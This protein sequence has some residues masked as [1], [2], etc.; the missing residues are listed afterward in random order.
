MLLTDPLGLVHVFESP[1][2]ILEVP[3]AKIP[4][5]GVCGLYR[6]RPSANGVCFETGDKCWK[7]ILWLKIQPLLYV[8]NDRRTSMSSIL[9]HE[10]RHHKDWM[11]VIAQGVAEGEKIEAKKFSSY[12]ACRSAVDNW[13]AGME[14]KFARKAFWF[15][16]WEK[17]FG[18]SCK[19]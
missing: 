5:P 9:Q 12:G 10:M 17:Y 1:L 13:A 6:A 11:D 19:L 15:H 18:E 4:T 7:A 3:G 8:A 16:Q 2:I 14:A